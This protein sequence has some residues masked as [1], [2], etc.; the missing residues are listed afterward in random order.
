MFLLIGLLVNLLQKRRKTEAILFSSALLRRNID[1]IMIKAT[2]S[3]PMT[4]AVHPREESCEEGES[5]DLLQKGGFWPI[6]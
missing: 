5:R 2:I 6:C 4:F 1:A 3:D